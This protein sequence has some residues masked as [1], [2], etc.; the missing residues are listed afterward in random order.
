MNELSLSRTV[1]HSAVQGL[2]FVGCSTTLENYI[3][4]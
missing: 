3:C 2:N 4:Q 1:Y